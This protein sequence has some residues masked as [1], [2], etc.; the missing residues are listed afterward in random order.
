VC[1]SK[2]P[3]ESQVL[4]LIKEGENDTEMGREI[5]LSALAS[6]AMYHLNDTV[7]IKGKKGED[8]TEMCKIICR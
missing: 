2:P 5:C 7:L 6:R 3:V 1:A 8:D 4:L